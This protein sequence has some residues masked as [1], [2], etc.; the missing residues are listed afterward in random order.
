MEK[1]HW[2]DF[3]GKMKRD[4]IILI[5]AVIQAILERIGAIVMKIMSNCV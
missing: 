3:S 2:H 5:F 4:Y 1:F